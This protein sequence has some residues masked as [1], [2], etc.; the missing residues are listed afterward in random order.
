M[1][2]HQHVKACAFFS[3]DFFSGLYLAKT[4]DEEHMDIGVNLCI[5]ITQQIIFWPKER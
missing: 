1:L 2:L 4:I 3:D 5:R